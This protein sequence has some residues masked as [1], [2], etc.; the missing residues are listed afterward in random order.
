M[1]SPSTE[2]YKKKTFNKWIERMELCVDDEG[3][4]LKYELNFCFFKICIIIT[5]CRRKYL[6][7]ELHG[8]TR[9]QR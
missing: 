4:D 1:Y 8:K 7:G 6:R 9:E 5:F 3:D 2:E